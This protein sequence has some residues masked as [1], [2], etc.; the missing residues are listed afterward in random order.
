MNYKK[1]QKY[2]IAIFFCCDSI[3]QMNLNN[4]QYDA[5]A[6]AEEKQLE[7]VRASDRVYHTTEN[8]MYRY[9]WWIVLVLAILLGLYLVM[10]SANQTNKL[11]DTIGPTN[12]NDPKGTS[13]AGG[14]AVPRLLGNS[15][16]ADIASAPEYGGLPTDLRPFFR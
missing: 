5:E 10:K 14:G 13:Q 3:K 7:M 15:F 12:T 2:R 11:T 1:I 4:N 16:L 6:E 9:R 8:F